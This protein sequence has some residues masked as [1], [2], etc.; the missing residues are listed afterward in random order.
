MSSDS[1][2]VQHEVDPRSNLGG[3]FNVVDFRNEFLS[4]AALSPAS[5]ANLSVKSL[6][7]TYCFDEDGQP[8][9]EVA[10]YMGPDEEE[11]GSQ[12]FAGRILSMA[13]IDTR[14]C[15]SFGQQG[16]VCISLKV[17]GKPSCS[18]KAHTRRVELRPGIYP[19]SG[20]REVVYPTQVGGMDSP[21]VQQTGIWQNL[22]D[23]EDPLSL[24][25][26][27]WKLV[28]DVMDRHL[29][30]RVPELKPAAS[31]S[32]GTTGSSYALVEASS[33]DDE[34][35]F[36]SP[37]L[38]NLKGPMAGPLESDQPSDTAQKAVA[39]KERMAKMK[40]ATK[41]GFDDDEVDDGPSPFTTPRPNPFGKPEEFR[42]DA[43]SGLAAPK[44]SADAGGPAKKFTR[45]EDIPQEFIDI[46]E[47]YLRSASGSEMLRSLLTEEGKQAIYEAQDNARQ[48]I[49]RVEHEYVERESK[50]KDKVQE[51]ER[52]AALAVDTASDAVELV[53]KVQQAVRTSHRAAPVPQGP[54]GGWDHQLARLPK[55]I[56]L[57]ED[58][59]KSRFKVRQV[60]EDLDGKISGVEGNLKALKTGLEK[61]ANR[62]TLGS[63][64][65]RDWNYSSPEEFIRDFEKL[66]GTPDDFG[67]FYDAFSMLHGLIDG[68]RT[69]AESLKAIETTLKAKVRDADQGRIRTSFMTDV[70]DSLIKGARVEES[71][72]IS[73]RATFLDHLK[74][75]DGWRTSAGT[76]M[77]DGLSRIIE[78]ELQTTEPS[79]ELKIE[80]MQNEKLRGLAQHMATDSLKFIDR[81]IRF[82]EKFFDHMSKS[83]GVTADEAWQLTRRMAGEIFERLHRSRHRIER[84][85]QHDPRYFVY[86]ALL[87]HQT[88]S[89]FTA[90]ANFEDHEALQ[91]ILVRFLIKQRTDLQGLEKLRMDQEK[92]KN[93]LVLTKQKLNTLDNKVKAGK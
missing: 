39:L 40:L 28:A 14:C 53:E 79:L 83:Q 9:Q 91:G 20:K 42:E 50:L 59:E 22:V 86:G 62:M 55:F 6:F 8:Y 67:L 7:G 77:D 92:L 2:G 72:V 85:G 74:S 41:D 75:F 70:P 71:G 82:T 21:L 65:Y 78:S 36:G 87:T 90:H 43:K 19:Q 37:D 23:P 32:S 33:E 66:G 4:A 81:F 56:T 89:G 12:A 47:L 54:V 27:Q 3:E 57:Q 58:L 73:A 25:L 24:S 26:G 15:S 1:F 69:Q 16:L 64:A 51:L 30:Q 48:A 38:F 35:R 44:P 17:A 49:Q 60:E 88:M 45:V 11:W 80:R 13:E 61:M 46:M 5:L 18:V 76:Y 63:V 52:T 34:T 10:P 93:D 68:Q 31:G 84:L 29:G